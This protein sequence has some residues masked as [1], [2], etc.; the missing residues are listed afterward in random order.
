MGGAG[1]INPECGC[2]FPRQSDAYNDFIDGLDGVN[3]HA[4]QLGSLACW[5]RECAGDDI[6][7]TS[8]LEGQTCNVVN[9]SC[10]TTIGDVIID[11]SIFDNDNPAVVATNACNLDYNNEQNSEPTNGG[12]GCPFSHGEE[13]EFDPPG[14]PCNPREPSN[15]QEPSTPREPNN[16][17]NAVNYTAWVIGGTGFA[18]LILM[19]VFWSY[20]I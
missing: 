11:D 17:T 6:L 18:V 7:K 10:S 9:L 2:I 19:F 5:F 12:N 1:Q 16:P 20:G 8:N 14:S 3:V 4:S 15:P 13:N